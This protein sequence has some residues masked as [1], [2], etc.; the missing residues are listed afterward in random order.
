VIVP[1]AGL[2]CNATGVLARY[3]GPTAGGLLNAS[4]GNA[5]EIITASFALHAGLVSMV[6]PSL[7]GSILGVGWK[8]CSL[9][10][11]CVRGRLLP[12]AEDRES[13]STVY[14]SCCGIPALKDRDL[15]PI[16]KPSRD[17][18]FRLSGL[19]RRATI[20]LL[21]AIVTYDLP[22]RLEIGG[23]STWTRTRAKIP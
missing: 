7:T 5:P 4:L 20:A 16:L 13:Q 11:T 17:L 22:F 21:A 6:K 23:R 3:L 18:P 19:K 2:V 10:S 9:P 8:V 12:P 14:P 15:Q 1:L